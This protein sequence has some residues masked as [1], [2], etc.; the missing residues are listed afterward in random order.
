MSQ[1]NA[2]KERTTDSQSDDDESTKTARIN[3]LVM[4]DTDRKSAIEA[5]EERLQK[6][7]MRRVR[8]AARRPTEV[9]T[10]EQK[11]SVPDLSGSRFAADREDGVKYIR[12]PKKPTEHRLGQGHVWRI[13]LV[14]LSKNTPAVGVD[15]ID[16]VVL[17][18]DSEQGSA[19]DQPDLGLTK[20][21]AQDKGVSRRHAMLRPTRNS[22]FLIDLESTN[23]TRINA[24]N[25][26]R[27][28]ARKLAN[29]DVVTLG[30]LT[31]TVRIISKPGDADV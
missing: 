12:L 21:G 6:A 19:S 14:E 28:T 25:I 30:D 10:D 9:L 17:G 20:Y 23:G 8:E 22:L 5:E 3:K 15:I 11:H 1:M 27:G 16:D 24:S 13:Q 29:D 18:R 4:S 31:F 7:I 26:G 2:D